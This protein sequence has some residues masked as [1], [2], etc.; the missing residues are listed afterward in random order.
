MARSLGVSCSP[1][2]AFLALLVDGAAQERPDRL[3][4]PVVEGS[5]RLAVS[6]D[7]ITDLLSEF[8][9][10]R[11]A[12]LLP[13]RDPRHK[14]VYETAATR[15]SMETLFRLAAVRAKISI[16]VLNR[17]T[18]RS[19]LKLAGKLELHVDR[20]VDPVGRYW[21]QGRAEAALAALASERA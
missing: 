14:W 12:V 8:G 6:E 19:R 9:V 7:E 21:R 11:V 13:E 5:E 18:V 3:L 4:W 2:A 1:A 15:A 10:E 17:E 16:E 20:L